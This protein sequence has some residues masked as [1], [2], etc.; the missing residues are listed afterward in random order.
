MLRTVDLSRFN[1]T[2]DSDYEIGRPFAVRVVW[3]LVGLP[4]LRCSILNSSAFRKKLLQLFG[5]EIGEG[6]VIKPGVRVKFPWKL[7][8]GKYSWIGEDC[9]IDNL[10]A[11][12]IGD[13]VCLSQGAYLCTGSHDWSDP[14]FR[15]ITRSIQIHDGAWI[16][17]QVSVAPGSVIGQHAVVGFGSVVSGSVPPY[18]IYSGNPAAFLR[19]REIT[20]DRAPRGARSGNAPREVGPQL[21]S[22]K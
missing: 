8:M 2:V 3:F 20:A 10:A 11:V 4:I 15:L 17:A 6:A 1:N 5:A 12:T 22:V 18:E 21:R 13:N 14:A 7:K 9:W 19:R 16:A